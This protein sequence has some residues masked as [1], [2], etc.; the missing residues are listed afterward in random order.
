[1][2]T[3][4][5]KALSLPLLFG[6]LSLVEVKA[7]NGLLREV[8]P[9]I[10]GDIESLTNDLSFP[11]APGSSEA[12]SDF[13]TPQNTGDYYGSRISGYIVAPQ[14]GPYTFAIASDDG[15]RLFLSTDS[16]PANKQLIAQVQNWTPYR[17]FEEAGE[18]L[19]RSNPINLVKG[20]RYYIEALHVDGN[21]SDFVTVRWTLPDGT[22]ETPIPNSQLLIEIIPPQ[23]TVDPVNIRR[24]EGE[25]AT[26]TIG[27]INRGPVVVQWERNGSPIPNATNLSL[28]VPVTIADRGA[29]YRA[30][31]TNQFGS[32]LSLEATLSVDPDVT[33][34]MLTGA[35]NSGENDQVI[36][37]FSEPINIATAQNIQNYGI[38]QG[39]VILSARLDE[40]GHTV[41]LQTTPLTF[42]G[43]YVVTV[44]NLRD[45]ANQSNLINPNSIANFSYNYSALPPSIAIRSKERLSASTR[46][47]GL[48]ISELMYNP[49]PLQGRNLEYIELY[50]SSE[51]IESIGGYR[52][53][54]AT[55][56]IFPEGTFIPAGGFIVVAAVPTD[57][58]SVYGLSKV[59]GGYN[60]PLQ[61]SSG[62]VRLHNELGAILLEARYGSQH[63]YPAAAD[64]AG[65]SL[66]LARP[67]YGEGDYRAWDASVTMG[68]SP[69]RA[70]PTVSNP[71]AT[72]MINEFL[73]HTDPPLT[74]FIELYNYSGQ[75]I[76]I[77]NC[78]LTDNPETNKFRIP[79][80]TI[81]PAF[82]FRVFNEQEL[83]FALSSQ[84]ESIY[85][86]NPQR[87]RVLDAIRF[88]PQPNGIA[89]GRF[90]DGNPRYQPLSQISPG[91]SNKKPLLP[92]IV[93]NEIMFDPISGNDDLD[94]FVELYNRSTRAINL[95][96]WRFTDGIEFQFPNITMQPGS[97]L[98]VARNKTNLLNNYSQLNSNNTIGDF[99]GN[100]ANGGE[101][102]ALSRPELIT[103]VTAGGGMVTNIV[104]ILVDEVRY[105]DGGR[106]G[107]WSAGGGSSLELLHAN[108]DND[109]GSS[110]ADSDET[111]K[112]EFV[113][114][115]H[116]GIL[117]HGM[118]NFS[119]VNPSMNLHLLMMG[120]SEAIFDNIEVI[121]VNGTNLLSNGNFEEEMKDWLAQGTHEDTVVHLTG[122]FTNSGSLHVKATAR[123][124]LSS[125]RVRGK[126]KSGLQPGSIATLRT[127][128]RWLR[129]N[130]EVLL[131]LHGNWLEA[132]GRLKVPRNLGTPGM[133]NSRALTNAGPS[134]IGVTHFPVLPTANQN[135]TVAAQI[136]DP[137]RVGFLTLKYRLDSSNA[138]TS[139]PMSYNGAGFYSAVIPGQPNGQGVAFYI[140]ASDA[141]GARSLF[142]ANAP[143][144]EGVIRFGDTQPPGSLASYYLWLSKK[145]LDRWASRDKSSN[146]G[147]DATFVYNGD[148]V[149][150]QMEALYSGS[151]F[152]WGG[153][154]SPIGF[155]AN[156]VL[157]FPEDDRLL[158][159]TDFVL[160]LPSNLGSDATMVREQIFFWIAREIGQISNHRRYHHLFINGVFRDDI[161]GRVSIFEDSQQPN[162]DMLDQWFSNDPD[163]DLYKIEDWFEFNDAFGFQNI[164]GTLDP[165][166]TTNLITNQK[167][168]KRE[169][170]RWTFRKRAVSDSFHDYDDLFKLVDALNQADP[171]T[172]GTLVENLVNIDNWMGA[173]AIRHAVGDWDAYG[174]SRGKNMYAYKPENGK[175]HLLHWDIAFAFG[176]GDGPTHDLYDVSHFDG[177]IDRVTQRM[178]QYPPFKRAYLRALARTVDAMNPSRLFPLIDAKSSALSANGVDVESAASMKEWIEQRRSFIQGELANAAASFGISFNGGANFTTN[179]NHITLTGTAPV[180]VQ[181]ILVNGVSF[182]VTWTGVN[183]WSLRYAL[184][185]GANPL[186]IQG[187]N[188]DG[189]L[190][191]GGTDTITVTFTG[192]GENVQDRVIINEIMYNPPVEDGGFIEL[193][194]TSSTIAFDLS[195]LRLNGV[196]FTIPGGTVISPGGFVV[197]ADNQEV[198]HSLYGNLIPVI[199]EY[200]GNLDNGGETLTL[201]RLG[202]NGVELIIDSVTYD[203]TAPWP[204][205]ADGDGA[206][207]QLRDPALDGTRVANWGAAPGIATPG[208]INSLHSTLTTFPKLWIN[209]VLPQNLNS[210]TDNSGEREPW[211]EL[212]NSGNTTLSLDQFF[213]TDNYTNL[214]RFQFPV[215]RTLS[216]GQFMLIWLDG[217]TAETTANEL[218]ASFRLNPTAGSIALVRNQNGAPVVLDYLNYSSLLPGRSWGAVPDGQAQF[219]EAFF[220]VT[221]GASNNA[222]PA[223]AQIFINE[224]MASNPNIIADPADSDFEDWFELFNAGDETVDLSGF[225]LSDDIN[226]KAQY[227]IPEGTMIA[228]RGFLLVWADEESA[229][230]TANNLHV[231]FKLDRSGDTIALFSAAGELIDAVTF[232][233]QAQGISEGR[234]VDGGESIIAMPNP[235]PGHSNTPIDPNALRAGAMIENETILI[236]WNS[237]IGESYRVDFK[238][239]LS[240]SEWSVLGSITA[241]AVSSSLS[242][243]VNETQRFYRIVE[244]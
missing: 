96:G 51:V 158:G 198:F 224:Y 6:W 236:T 110:W 31:V 100:L 223:P 240:D 82:G 229:Q 200:S 170:Y 190:V 68:G 177:S 4:I 111:Q 114:I 235:T 18:P 203:D 227:V 130:P 183:T 41:L 14:D 28:R 175:W 65:H 50:N 124:D 19:Q 244:Q 129:G 152:H 23:I 44:N 66:V 217:E 56:F 161:G 89:T 149:I 194:N 197:I 171:A 57:V 165:F 80:G 210:V 117:N 86:M 150:Y 133:V 9:N 204:I 141:N 136:T 29:K 49:A 176:L 237:K 45:R 47:T 125:N 178:M 70:E 207:L 67:S 180:E 105:E 40:D 17:S 243:T 174:Y 53:S 63:P 103:S 93:I 146:K 147:V 214:T 191:P 139:L 126:L 226:D 90:P 142:P 188:A 167:E 216:P 33:A 234:S 218:H 108:A 72:V 242:D 104:Q 27:L 109:F 225:I 189:L 230:T 58:Q 151:P 208:V 99:S 153:Y 173:I 79:A 238:N 101:R 42:G 221:P 43:N 232:G 10:F 192:A 184:K 145:N 8:Y 78:I 162:Q 219:R 196:D 91:S 97:Y 119:S 3:F 85:F 164:D 137:D 81:I 128:A 92:E 220:F 60:N 88:E 239:S 71:F 157:N 77:S 113:T 135:V 179:R 154:N 12:I 1:M 169:R 75:A 233:T 120:A 213:L 61:N 13:D 127:Q 76:D 168:Y 231:N 134:I 205:A 202:T 11:G 140:D 215:G 163:G 166:F 98:V 107:K 38:D 195:N 211:V 144:G 122:G 20:Q 24:T 160:N 84:G 143:V 123:G 64:G 35:F 206:S 193:H 74:D 241:T 94:E 55:D 21:G 138:F 172:Y 22:I 155:N 148:R 185:P 132:A 118:T 121:G 25:I 115:E 16:D 112:G 187:L 106:W 52:I 26:F 222:A 199:G 62:T 54:G 7:Q 209:E 95:A 87:T 212:F 46:R 32:D 131:R 186:S 48:V 39:I 228:P 182:P 156:Y 73:A 37:I 59:F 181:S 34:P 116:R 30:L 2:K 15:S 159:Q 69:G 83:G 36:L 102:L 5:L 201:Q